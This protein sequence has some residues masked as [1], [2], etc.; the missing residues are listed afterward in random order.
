MNLKNHK[1]RVLL[2]II[3]SAV[4]IFSIVN[5][6]RVFTY[7][8]LD[9]QTFALMVII[10]YDMLPTVAQQFSIGATTTQLLQDGFNPIILSLVS[11]FALLVGQMVMYGIGIIIRKIRKGSIGDLASKNHF[12]HKHHF[13]IYLIVPFVGILGDAVMLYSGHERIS[14]VKIIPYLLIANFFSSLRWILS[15]IGQIEIA[16]LFQ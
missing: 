16:Q 9:F 13:L 7:N 6:F 1:I 3:L 2:V 12:L 11:A 14:P 10:G 4:I 15:A 8:D 5:G